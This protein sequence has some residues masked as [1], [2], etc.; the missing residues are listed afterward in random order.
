MTIGRILYWL[1]VGALLGIGLIGMM[2]IGIFLLIPGLAL[3]IYGA[4]RLGGRGL[5]AALVG[6]GAAPALLLLWDVMSQPWACMPAN[7]TV[8]SPLIPPGAPATYTSPNYFACVST[9]VGQLT[10]Y[11]VMAAGF[12]AIAIVGLLLGLAPLLWRRGHT[13]GRPGDALPA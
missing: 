5:W 1:L 4:I 12:G 9:P 6:F 11:H 8:V 10:T 3:L 7:N 13:D 2:S